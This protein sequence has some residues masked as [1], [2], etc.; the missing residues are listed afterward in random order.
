MPAPYQCRHFL[1][2]QILCGELPERRRNDV[3]IPPLEKHQVAGYL[4]AGVFFQRKV[5][6]VLLGGGGK[7]PDVLVGDL[8]V[9]N[10]GVVLHQLPEGLLSVVQLGLMASHSFLH[11]VQHFF[12]GLLQ[13]PG[14]ELGGLHAVGQR[15][16]G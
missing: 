4:A 16:A 5:N 11:L 7:D 14:G 8:D 1:F 2:L 9:G 10:A 3:G 12:S 15:C 6:T 13:H